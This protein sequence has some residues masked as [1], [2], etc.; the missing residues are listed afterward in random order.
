MHWNRAV[1]DER[2]REVLASTCVDWAAPSRDRWELGS[3]CAFCQPSQPCSHFRIARRRSGLL[4]ARVTSSAGNLTGCGSPLRDTEAL[5]PAGG[6]LSEAKLAPRKPR[7]C[8][9]DYS[10]SAFRTKVAIDPS[11]CA[12]LRVTDS[13][14]RMHLKKDV[15]RDHAISLSRLCHRIGDARSNLGPSRN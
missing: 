1:D 2:Y 5:T 6:H 15:A 7:A 4:R 11:L 8:L 9:A 14:R 10:T 12:L 13:L 3:K